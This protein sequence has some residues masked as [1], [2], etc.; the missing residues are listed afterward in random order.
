MPKKK[1]KTSKKTA[2]KSAKKTAPKTGLK[3][4]RTS[5]KPK[6]NIKPK[7]SVK[8]PRIA[9]AP[10]KTIRKKAARIR[11][12]MAKPTV[13]KVAAPAAEIAPVKIANLQNKPVQKTPEQKFH[14]I[15]IKT[16]S[17]MKSP[18]V[19]DIYFENDT[20]N[21]FDQLEKQN[22]EQGLAID[23]T[24]EN[25]KQSAA[26]QLN[27]QDNEIDI[28]ELAQDF[29]K[30]DLPHP[31]YDLY[32]FGVIETLG[33]AL[34]K[35]QRGLIWP[36]SK[37]R[38]LTPEVTGKLVNS[39]I[40]RLT[41]PLAISPPRGWAR[42]IIS[43]VILGLV[44]ILPFQGF[45]YY[46][47]LKNNKQDLEQRGAEVKDLL[48]GLAEVE[49][50]EQAV[51]GLNQAQ[52][53]INLAQKELSQI[54]S[55]V[56]EI[57][58]LIPQSGKKV[59]A[60]ESLLA[61][62]QNLVE[63]AN[64]IAK[65][66]QNL[67]DENNNL[68]TRIDILLSYTKQSKPLIAQAQFQAEQI[69]IRALP[70]EYQKTFSLIYENL[71]YLNENLDELI[72]LG[73][74]MELM[75]GKY[76]EQR[77]I[78]VFENNNEIRPTGGF[79]GSF[80]LIDIDRGEIKNIE[81]PGGGTYDM[82]GSLDT[83]LFAP[84]P[85]RL[86]ADRW[87]LQDANWFADFPASAK[88]II[89][90]YEHSGGATPDGVIVMTATVM[91]EL[92]KIY[93]PIPMPDYGRTFTAENF[94]DEVQQI[95]EVEYDKEENKPKKVIGELTPIIL[96]K[97][98]HSNREQLTAMLGVIKASL[99]QKHL[100]IYHQSDSIMDQL[101]KQGWTG[102]IK[103]TDGDYL[104]I[105]NANI[106]GGKTDGVIS[107][108]IDLK[109][110]ISDQGEIINTLKITREHSGIKHQGF[111]GVNNVNYLRV[112]VPKGSELIN[113]S[114]FNPPDEELFDDP[115]ESC[116]A[117]KDLAETEGA[118]SFHHSGVKINNEFDKT[119]FGAWTQTMPGQ[120]TIVEFKYRLPYRLGNDAQVSFITTLKDKLGF[121]TTQ[122]YT[123][124]F[125]KQAGIKEIDYN[126]TLILP[127]SM[128]A[129]WTNVPELMNGT[130]SVKLTTD[131]FF[132]LLLEKQ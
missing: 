37:F 52:E 98:L 110:E 45:T 108:N 71:K 93:G 95:V 14:T 88:K 103:S 74:T 104:M 68:I 83:D 27:V 5:K 115:R 50:L 54:N 73:E 82:Q 19:V 122:A 35:L 125:Q 32:L 57:A 114:G 129:L 17:T 23:Q 89:W 109:T 102:R 91:E 46:K 59:K 61:M 43:L 113:A 99:Y 120:K 7:S 18:F 97:I 64:I 1:K 80:A 126:H 78:F 67:F 96:E 72:A 130:I 107:Q 13:I 22:F 84:D 86:I 12:P 63:A 47:E 132:A 56:L 94:I 112:Y 31:F 101:D 20:P 79:M 44:M 55:L 105:V 106:A 111:S 30:S 36:F 127:N 66:L 21:R 65:G 24:L 38:S 34:C 128:Q 49:N 9:T 87:E 118:W 60:G 42:G 90:F 85:L 62:G 48:Q 75:M 29:I 123:M 70:D 16:G 8:K 40:E 3:I 33:L 6:A 51:A 11:R 15:P 4:R 100:L 41:A 25:I 69:D 92:L 10:K 116:V 119:V 131:E 58:G 39:P 76:Q 124:F 117:D 81:V 53:T 2:K 77:Y 121:P 28:R 26:N